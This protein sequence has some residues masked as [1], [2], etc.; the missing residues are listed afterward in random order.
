MYDL[1]KP[2]NQSYDSWIYN[3][4]ASLAVGYSVFKGS[5]KHFY[6]QNA[7]CYCGAVNFYN[8]SVVT[9]DRRIGCPIGHS[10]LH[11]DGMYGVTGSDPCHCLCPVY[12]AC[13]VL[14]CLANANLGS[15]VRDW[16]TRGRTTRD[17]TAQDRTPRDRTN[18]G[19][20]PQDRSFVG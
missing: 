15:T 4:N 8:A 13:C 1:T 11:T 2:K 3:Y 10:N 7:L 9:H 5:T 16:T 19:R 17:R 12:L 14:S 6:F 20:S 18:R